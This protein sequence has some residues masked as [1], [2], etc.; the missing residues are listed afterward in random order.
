M[1]E[2]KKFELIRGAGGLVWRK[3]NNDWEI[4]VIH[5]TRYD[6]WT[7]P[8]GKLK[9]NERWDETALREV[10]EETGY[11]VSLNSFAGD[12]FYY[13]GDIPKIVLLW[14]MTPL[15]ISP[16]ADQISDSPDEGDQQ[17]WCKVSEA[18]ELISY[19]EERALVKNEAA[20]IKKS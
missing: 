17:K 5:R 2:E 18:L 11:Q 6:D 3:N 16:E 14:N 19:A 20:R 4:L 13:V 10:F 1:N 7:L 8:K 12:L 15:E 9:E